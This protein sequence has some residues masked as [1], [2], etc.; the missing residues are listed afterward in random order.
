MRRNKFHGLWS[1]SARESMGPALLRGEDAELRQPIAR[2]P[3]S[4]LPLSRT[5][6]ESKVFP[7]QLWPAKWEEHNDAVWLSGHLVTAL[8]P[9]L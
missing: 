3:G 4:V 9:A 7:E 2:S 8:Q 6:R 1:S 5:C